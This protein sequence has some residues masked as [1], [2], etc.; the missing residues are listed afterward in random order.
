MW[1]NRLQANFAKLLK[2]EYHKEAFVS[3]KESK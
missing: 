1:H 2:T 3:V